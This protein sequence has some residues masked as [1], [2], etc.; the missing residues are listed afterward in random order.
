MI[1]ADA[2]AKTAVLAGVEFCFANPGTTE[3][4]LV[5]AFDATSGIRSILGLYEGVCTG[6]A[7]GYGRMTGRPAFTLL[8]QGPGLANGLA[9]LHNARRARSPVVN[10]IG[11]H[12][13]WH[14]K[15]NSPLTSDIMG[16]ARPVSHWVRAVRNARDIPADTA[17]ALTSAA[18]LPGSVASLIIPVDCQTGESLEPLHPKPP[19]PLSVVPEGTINNVA[20]ALRQRQPAALLLGG[21]ALRQNGLQ[22]AMRIAASSGCH[23]L[24]ETFPARLERG[25]GIPAVEKLP[26]F[27]ERAIECLSSFALLILAG[28]VDPVAFFGY[29][30]FPS[31]LAPDSCETVILAK[32]DEDV[33]G[34]MQELGNILHVAPDMLQTSPARPQRPSG[35]LSPRSLGEA[36]AAVQPEG[37]IL[38]DE[39][40]TSGQPY[41]HLS[42]GAPPFTYMGITGGAIGMGM[43]LAIGAALAC[44]ERKVLTLQADGSGLYTVQALWTQARENLNITTIIC[45]NRKY[46]ILQ[47]E[48]ARAGISSP[49]PESLALTELT[50]PIIDWL[51]ISRGFG[52]SAVRVETAEALA[53]QIERALAEP[54]PLLIEAVI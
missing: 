41:F 33:V 4:P 52:V 25:R 44:P 6:A 14:I 30:G 49:G 21:F 47:L 18:S 50:N 39:A 48:L 1:G 29:P 10:L 5:T 45:A 46:R 51:E 23:L 8:H 32:P 15:A 16:L 53:E 43:P 35:K 54:G 7:D 3:L 28:A 38:V 42:A 31:R 17:Q 13:T 27:P 34:A 26:Y 36:I 20:L 40:A 24:C 22:A 9:N 11:E 2:L 19:Q 12:A 37:L